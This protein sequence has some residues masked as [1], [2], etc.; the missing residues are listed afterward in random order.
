MWTAPAAGTEFLE[1]TPRLGLAEGLDRQ[2]SV[3]P[4]EIII[5]TASHGVLGEPPGLKCTR[6]S[7]SAS[8][9]GVASDRKAQ[10]YRS[11]GNCSPCDVRTSVQAEGEAQGVYSPGEAT[12]QPERIY[13]TFSGLAG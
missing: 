4:G 13:Q 8:A 5:V 12:G 10:C 9:E 3:P 1:S 11:S 6:M 7:V 2:A